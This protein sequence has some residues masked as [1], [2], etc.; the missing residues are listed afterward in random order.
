MKIEYF[1]NYSLLSSKAADLIVDELSVKREL[2]LCAASGFSPELTYRMFSEKVIETPELF[3]RLKIIKLDEWGGIS[4]DNAQ[5]CEVFLQKNLIQPLKISPERY[6]SFNSNSENPE[7]ECNRISSYLKNNGPV[8][9]CV[10]GLGLNG[11]IAFN[12]PGDFLLPDCHIATLSQKSMSHPMAKEMGEIPTYGLTIGMADILQSKKIIMIVT[13]NG[14]TEIIN[15]F[16]SGKITT[17]LPASFL[18]T[19]P[20]VACFIDKTSL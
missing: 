19:H 17:K 3:E 2:L 13:G 14:K 15:Q 9:V 11:H 20:N 5:S 12:E 16:L 4:M 7:E 6:I 10:L 1:D 18:W 8:D